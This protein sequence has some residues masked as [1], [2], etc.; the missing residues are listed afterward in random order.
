VRSQFPRPTEAPGRDR[1]P[2]RPPASATTN[3]APD[4]PG[5]WLPAVMRKLPEVLE[6]RTDEG[7]LDRAPGI[8]GLRTATFSP[9]PQRCSAYPGWPSGRSCGAGARRRHDHPLPCRWCRLDATEPDRPMARPCRRG[10]SARHYIT[11]G[12]RGHSAA[13]SSPSDSC[14]RPRTPSECQRRGFPARN[15]PMRSVAAAPQSHLLR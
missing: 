4:V 15:T 9:P 2:T 10:A 12:G 6:G 8:D 14:S 5:Y 7:Q 11:G 1:S 13:S 3:L